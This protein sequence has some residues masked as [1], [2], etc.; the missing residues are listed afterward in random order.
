MRVKLY[1]I[2]AFFRLFACVRV[3]EYVCAHSL[4]YVLTV[5]PPPSV[6]RSQYT[7]SG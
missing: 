6:V 2:C 4:A 3:C 1:V 5:H 7:C